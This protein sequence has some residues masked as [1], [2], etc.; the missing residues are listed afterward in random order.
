MWYYRL[1]R[2][3][4]RWWFAKSGETIRDNCL[5]HGCSEVA[6]ARQTHPYSITGSRR[7]VP[8]AG[9]AWPGCGWSSVAAE[10]A[11][12]SSAGSSDGVGTGSEGWADGV[13][14]LPKTRAARRKSFSRLRQGNNWGLPAV[15][16]SWPSGLFGVVASATPLAAVAGL[17]LLSEPFGSAGRRNSTQGGWSQHSSDQWLS[18]TNPSL[19]W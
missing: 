19:V 6:W 8:V 11:P 3:G 5:G 1:F 2:K 18:K 16:S 4:I 7:L 14:S 17:G 9:P 13:V 12:V 10:V 15:C